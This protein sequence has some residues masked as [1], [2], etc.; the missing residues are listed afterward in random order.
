[1]AR[2]QSRRPQQ[3]PTQAD[4]A[5]RLAALSLLML[6]MLIWLFT[7]LLFARHGVYHPGPYGSGPGGSPFGHYVQH[8]QLLPHVVP[9]HNT[10]P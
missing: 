8:T 6:A 1:M 4:R 5:G 7:A 3:P 10:S 2:F 9:G